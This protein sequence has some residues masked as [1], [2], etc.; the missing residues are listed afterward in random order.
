MNKVVCEKCCG[1]KDIHILAEY[2]GQD[3][4]LV[5][6]SKLSDPSVNLYCMVCSHTFMADKDDVICTKRGGY[7]EKLFKRLSPE[8][9]KGTCPYV[10]EH[11]MK[12]FNGKE[13]KR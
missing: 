9:F 10:L 11:L 2:A 12:Q 6:V 7:G 13:S 3:R 1:G 5:Q 4:I 8:Y